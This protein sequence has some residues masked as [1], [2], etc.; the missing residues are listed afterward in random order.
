MSAVAPTHGDVRVRLSPSVGAIASRTLR[1]RP[2]RSACSRIICQQRP[3]RRLVP[4]ILTLPRRAE[5]YLKSSWPLR[6][7][8]TGSSAGLGYYAGNIVTLT[9]GAL[10]INDVLAAV[11]TLL[12]YEAVSA[13]FYRSPTRPLRL[14]MANFFKAGLTAALLADAVKLGG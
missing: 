4:Y 12:F 7:L 11:V 13:A 10:S 9:F 3:P 2:S 8:W 6:I 14:W 5:L 1:H